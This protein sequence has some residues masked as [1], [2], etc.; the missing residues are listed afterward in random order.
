V[1]RELELALLHDRLAAVRAGQG[2]VVGLVGEPGMGKTRLVTEF[3][4][5]LVGQPVTVYVGQCLSYGQITPYLLVRDL[6]RQLCGLVEGDEVAVHT[7]AV[8]H[9]LHASGISAE[10]D[11]AMVCQLLDL[12]VA[13]ECLARRSPEA[14][15][16][17]T[18]ALLRHRIFDTAQQQPLALVV[19]NLHWSDA[20]SAAWFTSLVERLAGAAVLLLGTTRPG[21]QLP[22]GTHAAAT[23]CA[24]APLQARDSRV[25]VQAVLGPVS[26]PAERLRAMVAQAGG[27]LFFLE[28]LAWHAREQDQRDPPGAVPETVHTVLAARMDRLPPEAKRLLQTAAVLEMQMV[29]PLLQAVTELS[30]AEILIGLTQL[31]AAEFLS[32]AR[33]VPALTYT[34]KHALTH[35]GAYQSLLR[36]TRQQYHQR[37]VQVLVEQF[38]DLIE[39]QPELVSQHDTEAGRTE[40]AIGYWQ[41]AAMS[42][43]RLWQQQGKREEAC[44]LLAP[45]DG[46]FTEGSDTADLQEARVLLDV[47]A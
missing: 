8:Q 2:Q 23:Q 38:P 12:P 27:N 5:S 1:G 9:Q 16:A 29:L 33:L 13:P 35:E 28:E 43:T 34:F 17:R 6:L 3:C 47:Q 37:T 44:A 4:R 19:E 39:T 24:L 36:S 15:Q 31:Q 18:F 42:L 21:Y 11:V 10:E 20:T 22:W 25:V 26:L 41:R 45:I 30:D 32:E 40:Q 7:A 14:R 46:W